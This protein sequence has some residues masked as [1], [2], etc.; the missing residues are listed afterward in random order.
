[1]VQIK[2]EIIEQDKRYTAACVN[3]LSYR[4]LTIW[5]KNLPFNSI[6]KPFLGSI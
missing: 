3:L 6:I 5:M 1:M 4:I 2:V